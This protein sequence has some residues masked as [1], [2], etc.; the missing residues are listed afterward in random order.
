MRT[1]L[2]FSIHVCLARL[3]EKV[4]AK[5]FTGVN[6]I[7]EFQIEDNQTSLDSFGC[8]TSPLDIF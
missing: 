3:A 6:F 4:K 2:D 8:L 5:Q 7:K 1:K